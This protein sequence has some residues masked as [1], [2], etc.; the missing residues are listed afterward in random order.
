MAE[1]IVYNAHVI[2]QDIHQPYAEAF[3]VKEGKIIGVGSNETILSLKQ[4]N[5]KLVNAEGNTV[6]PGFIDAHIHVWKVGNLKTFLLDLRGVQSIDEMQDRLNDFIKQNPGNGWVQARGFN[7]ATMKEKRLPTKKDLDKVAAGRPLW[8]IRTCA[9][10]G[11][12]NSMAMEL[13]GISRSTQVPA[14]GEMRIDNNGDPNGIFT[15]SALGLIT[16]HIPPYSKYDYNIMIHAAEEVLLRYGITS[17]TD[18]AVMPDLL[19][20]YQYLHDNNKL[21][22]RVNAFPVRIPDGGAEILPLPGLYKSSSFNISIAKFFADGGLSGMT[23][24]MSKPYKNSAST[25]ILRLKEDFFYP[26]AK[27]TA[28]KGFGIATHAIGDTA[29]DVVLKVYQRIRKEHP[30]TLLRIEHLGLPS[31]RH[32]QLMREQNIHCVSQS[33]FLKE[34]GRNFSLYLEEERLQKIYPYRDVLNANVNL[35]LSS[36]APVVNDF[37][38]LTGIRTAML[39]KDADANTIGGDQKLSLNECLHAYTLAA[40][41][42]NGNDTFT[43]SIETGKLADFVILNKKLDENHVLDED[44]KVNMTYVGGIRKYNE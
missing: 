2:T 23:A 6:L 37:N 40:A 29:I 5:T 41:K 35:A 7:E 4:A 28:A 27:E 39:R 1:L 32:L 18:P 43:G 19:G 44:L 36:D 16:Q 20:I 42:A 24:A 38:P 25:G 26:V 10:I 34:L 31:T 14:G 17:A 33:I 22:V 3:A 21:Q 9:H 8:I 12:A 15:E 30:D 13:S 11:V